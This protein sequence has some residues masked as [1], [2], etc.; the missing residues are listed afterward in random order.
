MCWAFDYA[1]LL[2]KRISLIT[3]MRNFNEPQPY[4]D[5]ELLI[6]LYTRKTILLPEKRL[7]PHFK[8]PQQSL[9]CSSRMKN[10]LGKELFFPDQ[11]TGS[12]R[13]IRI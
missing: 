12:L 7:L 9:A 13:S 11:K 8:T 2:Y 10:A 3:V 6:F 4:R 1:Q 5:N